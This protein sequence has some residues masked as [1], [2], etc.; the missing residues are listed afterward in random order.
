[1]PDAKRRRGGCRAGDVADDGGVV[2]QVADDDDVGADAGQVFTMDAWADAVKQSDDQLAAA[3]RLSV[4]SRSAAAGPPATAA[5][6]PVPNSPYKDGNNVW[7]VVAG[8]PVR[9][10]RI[11]E[12]KQGTPGHSVSV[13]CSTHKGC[14][15]IEQCKNL[16]DNAEPMMIQW[17]LAGHVRL[18]ARDQTQAH[19]ALPEPLMTNTSMLF[20]LVA[21]SEQ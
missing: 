18:N 7:L 20:T 19:R 5:T 15:I 8:T 3:A 12:L 6:T 14:S 13:Y 1:M 11:T 17:L 2:E 21:N 16:P 9:L 10:G 4:A